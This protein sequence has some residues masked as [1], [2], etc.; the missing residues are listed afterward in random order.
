MYTVF[1]VAMVHMAGGWATAKHPK[2]FVCVVINVGSG[3]CVPWPFFFESGFS[4]H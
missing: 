2:W 4:Q 1:G 3:E